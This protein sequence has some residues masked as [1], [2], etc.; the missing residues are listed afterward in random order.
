MLVRMNVG[1]SAGAVVCCGRLGQATV[2]THLSR[3]SCR[4]GRILGL[5]PRQ[6]QPTN[7]VDDG[8]TLSVERN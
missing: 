5:L 1:L 3:E 8:R 7:E 6:R 2:L 4:S